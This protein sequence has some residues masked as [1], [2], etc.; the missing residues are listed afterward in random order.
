MTKKERL[1]SDPF[2]DTSLDWIQDTRKEKKK[3]DKKD[4]VDALTSK[5][6]SVKASRR[7]NAKASKRQSV[8]TSIKKKHYLSYFGT[9]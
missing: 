6:F 7:Q 2:Q 1:G 5:R 3:E 4:D 9:I 8:K